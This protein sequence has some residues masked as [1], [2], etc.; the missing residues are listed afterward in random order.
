MSLPGND[1]NPGGYL[2]FVITM[3]LT[4]GFIIYMSLIHPGVST[5]PIQKLPQADARS[6][7]NKVWESSPDQVE[8]GKGIY[9]QQCA[10]CHGDQGKGDG[11]AGVALKAK[12]FSD[13]EGWKNGTSPFG[14][15]KTIMEGIPGTG[16]APFAA[17]PDGDKWAVIHF[18]RANLISN[19]KD[20]SEEEITKFL[21]K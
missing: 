3:V 14:L 4:T 9:A 19:P 10:T 7:D 1:H 6:A 12:N 11:P 18:I 5:N 16:M 8:K 13:P 20:A 15:F 21:G 17:I 2:T